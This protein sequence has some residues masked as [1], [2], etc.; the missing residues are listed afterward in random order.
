[1]LA[2]FMFFACL[3]CFWHSYR[4]I[5]ALRKMCVLGFVSKMV[6][7]TLCCTLHKQYV[8][9]KRSCS[10]VLSVAKEETHD[11]LTLSKCQMLKAVSQE[12]KHHRII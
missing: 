6:S 10:R 8:I 9:M 4:N 2:C 5:L 12:R 1:M 11:C 7:P 3:I